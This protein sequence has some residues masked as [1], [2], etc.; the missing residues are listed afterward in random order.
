[1]KRLVLVLLLC[2]SPAFA[3]SR[4]EQELKSIAQSLL[5]AVT[6]GDTMAWELNLHRDFVL[7]DEEGNLVTRAAMLN[8]LRAL[9]PVTSDRLHLGPTVVRRI[10]N[11]AI[12]NHRD[13][14]QSEVYGQPIEA[15]YQ[16]TDTYV[17]VGGKW[18]LI[19]SHVMALPAPRKGI[20]IDAAK[21]RDAEGTYEVAPGITYSVRAVDGVLLGQ[22]S[23]EAPEKLLPAGVDLYFREGTVRGEKLLARDAG[24]NVVALVDRR[25]NI[26]VVW[27]KVR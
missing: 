19:A 5:D 11:V 16:T 26:D 23:G 13:R 14:E 20:A 4:D 10:G 8:H 12:L 2:A 7:T 24:G 22:R 17:K 21:L 18:K 27:K 1:M 6:H 9:P 15:E 25:D 3:Q